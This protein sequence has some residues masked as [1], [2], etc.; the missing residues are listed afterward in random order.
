[1]LKSLGLQGKWREA[2]FTRGGSG[3]RKGKPLELESDPPADAGSPQSSV[4]QLCLTLCS[5][6]ADCSSP[7]SS[8]YGIL[9][10]RILEWVAISFSML[11]LGILSQA[12]FLPFFRWGCWSLACLPWEALSCTVTNL[13][14]WLFRPTWCRALGWS[15]GFGD[16]GERQPLD[17]GEWPPAG[18][19]WESSKGV[20]TAGE[21]GRFGEG[22]G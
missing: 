11:A 12:D 10:A 13:P 21:E 20:L 7:G 4:T 1:M 5:P 6:M 9:Q 22:F 18:L 16:E 14:G 17:S 8:V 3:W 19:P 15:W 2:V